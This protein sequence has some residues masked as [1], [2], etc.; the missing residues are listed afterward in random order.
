MS[1][2]PAA[3]NT[4][5]LF[6]LTIGVGAM[7]ME[8]A[9]DAFA[10]QR[11]VVPVTS[12]SFSG[13]T[14]KGELIPGTTADWIRMEPDLTAHLDVRLVLKT[15]KGQ[16]IYMTYTGIRTGPEEVLARVAKGEQVDPSSYYFRTAVR[17][18][19]GDPELMDLNRVLGVGIGQRLPEGPIYDV[20]LVR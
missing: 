15:D 12:G 19:T 14:M 10:G 1:F 18:E 13:P 5:F 8:T 4:E 2:I 16:T 9:K 7:Q 3:L 6:R 20:Y 11:R 17:F